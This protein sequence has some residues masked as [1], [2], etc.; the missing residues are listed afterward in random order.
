MNRQAIK[1]RIETAMTKGYATH[2][3]QQ[4]ILYETITEA[5][6]AI[7]DELENDKIVH[8]QIKKE[9]SV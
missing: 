4:R 2:R 8:K 9:A 7:I 1:Q 6:D 5:V 3:I